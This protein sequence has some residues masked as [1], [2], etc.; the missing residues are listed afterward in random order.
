MF[1]ILQENQERN[2]R[3]SDAQAAIM[4]YTP[5]QRLASREINRKTYADALAELASSASQLKDTYLENY[6]NKRDKYFAQRLG[7]QDEL[8]EIYKNTSNQYS[9]A[10][11]NAF[12]EGANQLSQI[13]V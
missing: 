11:I 5:E 4:G 3:R 12:K 2:D 10:S 7:M 1:R 8:A 6:Q 9:Q 13:K